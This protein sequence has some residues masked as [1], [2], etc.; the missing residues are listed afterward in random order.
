M[1]ALTRETMESERAKFLDAL[2]ALKQHR[3][4]D[5]LTQFRADAT[6]YYAVCYLFV[7]AIE[8]LVDIGQFLLASR[9]KRAEG[10]REVMTLLAHEQVI[11]EDLAA[12]L[13]H[14]L[15][16]RNILIHVYPNL[17]DAKVASY[18]QNNL[19]DF[20]AFLAAVDRELGGTKE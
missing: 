9:G 4:P 8:S 6:T 11:T 2:A 5:V 19:D 16:F 10:Q 12:R 13:Q 20:D 15:G 14:A 7:I 3:T 17:D 1:T 18:L